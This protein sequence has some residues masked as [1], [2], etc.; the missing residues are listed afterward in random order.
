MKINRNCLFDALNIFTFIGFALAQP[1]FDLLSR[2]A[3]FFIARHS[4]PLDIILLAVFLCL[5]FPALVVVLGETLGVLQQRIRRCYYFLVVAI[6]AE[7]FAL[8]IFKRLTG[9]SGTVTLA[10][11][12]IFALLFALAYVRFKPFR[13]NL[14]F[15]SPAI[16]VFPIWFLINSS[17]YEII[18]PGKPAAAIEVSVGNPA[19]IFVVVFDEFPVTSLM[20]EERVID[21]VRYPNFAALADDSYWFRN[22]TTISS[23]TLLSIP[24]ILSGRFPMPEEYFPTSSHHPNQLFT[25]LGGSYKIKSFEVLTELCPEALCDET[26][27]KNAL[28]DRMQSLLSDLSIVYLHILLPPEFSSRLP[29]ITESWKDFGKEAPESSGSDLGTFF[30]GSDWN[31]KWDRIDWND[32]AA[33]FNRF[34]DS[35]DRDDRQTIFFLHMLFPHS[36]WSYLPSGKMHT[37]SKDM[38]VRGAVGKNSKGL[39]ELLW[40][41]DLWAITQMLQRHLLQVGFVDK[42]LGDL[43]SRLKF[44]DLYDPSLIVITADH[45]I[46][47]QPETNRRDASSTNYYDIMAVPLLIKAPRQK[48]GMVS[49]RNIETIDI[50]PTIADVLDIDLPWTVDGQSAIALSKPERKKKI[51]YNNSSER[52]VFE[53]IMDA[54]YQTLDRIIDVFGSGSRDSLYGIGAYIGLI[55]QEVSKEEIKQE[56]GF[57]VLLQYRH[58]Y[59]NLKLDA[60]F[61][62]ANVMGRILADRQVNQPLNLAVAVNGTIRAVTETYLESGEIKFSALVPEKSFRPGANEVDIYFARGPG[63][64]DLSRAIV[65]AN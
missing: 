59:S 53:P 55:G 44:M 51:I 16:L 58:L 2:N 45:G 7:C 6:L 29:A 3:E 36:A 40:T 50:L 27:E 19:P 9:M 15:L 61:I 49:D 4:E 47:F 48:L 39:D 31:S 26:K 33:D 11:A 14:V 5:L 10:A 65:K 35:I 52:H 13:A 57:E 17:I 38:D 8:L 54:K 63:I 12:S 62:P 37:L 24:S 41:D 1:L 18:F 23:D 56:K 22:A 28:L 34:I 32:R 64:S 60:N 42:L 25:L 43:I 21:P 46:S 30:A 20:N